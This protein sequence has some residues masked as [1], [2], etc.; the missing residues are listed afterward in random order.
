[1][2]QITPGGSASVN[3]GNKPRSFPLMP[4][5]WPLTQGAGSGLAAS[6]QPHQSTK[7]AAAHTVALVQSGH[8]SDRL[9]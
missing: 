3:G 2:A 7:T 1:M 8:S 5:G 6:T 9:L 4:Q